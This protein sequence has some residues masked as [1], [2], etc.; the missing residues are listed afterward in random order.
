[1]GIN[2]HYLEVITTD[3]SAT[4]GMLSSVHNVTFSQPE[5][6]LGNARTADL[7]DGGRIGVRLP[8]AEHE[9]PIVRPYLRVDVIADAVEGA[10][11]AGAQIAMEPTELPGL[12]QFA[13]VILAGVQHGFWQVPG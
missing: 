3:L 9:D 2:I 8:M 4:C 10:R 7:P 12:G 13:I 1:M 5:A 11:K 6:M